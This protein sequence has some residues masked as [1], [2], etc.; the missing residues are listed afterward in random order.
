MW[1]FV[2][3]VKTDL[4]EEQEQYMDLTCKR[5][6][7]LAFQL[8]F[9]QVQDL[10]KYFTKGIPGGKGGA[11]STASA[12]AL[13]AGSS[14]RSVAQ[15]DRAAAEFRAEESIRMQRE[16]HCLRLEQYRNSAALSAE[17]CDMS[18]LQDIQK[19]L[20]MKS[21]F[22]KRGTDGADM[23]VMCDMKI[24]A[25]KAKLNSRNPAFSSPTPLHTS[26]RSLTPITPIQTP[27]I[28]D[29]YFNEVE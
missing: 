18:A 23:V 2:S 26:N 17:D 29:N 20:E 6:D 12:A 19:L 8:M 21:D 11:P 13:P 9:E 22:L 15:R 5:W 7:S 14:S 16:V 4:A 28:L 24:M 10:T 3:P 1:F 25:L 27:V